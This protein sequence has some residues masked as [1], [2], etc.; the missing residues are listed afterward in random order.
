MNV[1]ELMKVVNESYAKNVNTKFVFGE[2]I[3]KEGVVV[4]PVA[5]VSAKVGESNTFNIKIGM[6]STHEK[7][8]KEVA[9]KDPDETLEKKIE[10]L[11]YGID[12][13]MSPMGYIE[14]KDG[15]A[16]YHPIIDINRM[17]MAGICF[18]GISVFLF[19][20]MITRVAKICCKSKD[21]CKCDCKED[22]EG[23]CQDKK[24]KHK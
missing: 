3:E 5:K 21:K 22:Q 13:K 8:P 18:A 15:A 7:V 9:S 1:D 17:G 24:K 20:R 11:G 16:T 6:P 19:T 2:P 23:C 10:K 12:A 4:I 14:I